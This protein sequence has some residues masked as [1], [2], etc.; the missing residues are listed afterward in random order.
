MNFQ[1]AFMLDPL[2]DNGN[3]RRQVNGKHYFW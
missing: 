1:V 2:M 3:I